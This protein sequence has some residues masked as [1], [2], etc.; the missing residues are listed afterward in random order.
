MEDI[1]RDLGD[2]DDPDPW[3][4]S[5]D[6]KDASRDA[7]MKTASNSVA[8]SR[9]PAHLPH[10]A[11]ASSSVSPSPFAAPSR[12][13][14]SKPCEQETA[15]NTADKGNHASSSR[16][17]RSQADPLP[18]GEST[19]GDIEMRAVGRGPDHDRNRVRTTHCPFSMCMH[20]PCYRVKL[21]PLAPPSTSRCTPITGTQYMY[22]RPDV[23]SA[24]M[25][26]PCDR[27]TWAP[28]D[29]PH[30]RIPLSLHVA[31]QE[32]PSSYPHPPSVL[33]HPGRIVIGIPTLSTSSP[34]LH[35][36][37][38]HRHHLRGAEQETDTR[39]HVARPSA[40]APARHTQVR[41]WARQATLLQ[42]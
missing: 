17:D 33:P 2:P 23:P 26:T 20:T 42:A 35:L 12:E 14:T 4:W 21:L 31:R 30:P 10:I 3:M 25:H 19:S 9:P 40:A 1:T 28:P 34:L 37:I 18:P 13:S 8:L 5:F 16:E 36:L 22:V 15:I 29:N 38:P 24:C 11:S 6:D 41:L 7:T 39:V 27:A 32:H